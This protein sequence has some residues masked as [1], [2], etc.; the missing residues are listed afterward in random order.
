MSL[1]LCLHFPRLPL[2]CLSHRQEH[3]AIVIERQRVT[4]AN[5]VALAAGVKP[6]QSSATVRAL[7]D[8][9][10]SRF[11][12]A[13]TP[14]KPEPWRNW[15]AGPIALP[16]PLNAGRKRASSW[17]SADASNCT[18]DSKNCW[19]MYRPIY[20]SAASQLKPDSRPIA[21]LLNYWVTGRTIL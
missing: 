6:E 2:E 3:P 7:V 12:S 15:N 10:I 16:Q 19:E 5:D 18:V 17:K 4:V 20:S 14:R 11:L 1:W 13:T 8:S 21:W 9:P